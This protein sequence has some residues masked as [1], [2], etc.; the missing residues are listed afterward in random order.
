MQYKTIIVD[1]EKNC[2]EVL[3]ILIQNNHPEFDI[4]ESFTSSKDALSFLQNNT[5][6]LVFMDIQMP[7]LSGIE[8]LQKIEDPSF[9]VIFTTAFDHYAIE[10]IKLSALDY[11]LKPI[12]DQ[13]LANTLERFKKIKESNVQLQL[14]QLLQQMQAPVPA[15]ANPSKDR[16]AISFQEKISFYNPDEISYC[17][18]S[19]NYTSVFLTN[20]EK[21]TASKTIKHF[22]EILEPLGFIRT[23]QSYLVNKEYLKEYSKKDGGYIILSDGTNIPVSRQR[24]EEILQLF[25]KI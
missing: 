9:Y 6:D 4:L 13:L 23:H 12:D 17:Q 19:D 24:K 7:F 20:G 3:E 10:A 16:I 14:K 5:V 2:V 21:V 15:V 25:K 1:D 8:L 22:E 18:S 11:L